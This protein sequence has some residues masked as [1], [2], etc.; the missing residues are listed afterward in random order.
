MEISKELHL[1]GRSLLTDGSVTS[2][3]NMGHL[4]VLCFEGEKLMF[5]SAV[6][7]INMDFKEKLWVIDF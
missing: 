3:D 5:L 1:G 2:N 7:S 4:T 6:P